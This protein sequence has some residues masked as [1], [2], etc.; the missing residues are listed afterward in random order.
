MCAPL[1]LVA[2]QASFPQDV[3][4]PATSPVEAL[5]L[6]LAAR[7]KLQD[8]VKR[9]HYVEA[10]QILIDALRQN[11]K[12]P[13][14]LTF[15]GGIYFLYGDYAQSVVALK[16][17]ER[18]SPLGN[19]DRFTLAMAYVILK[20]SDMAQPELERL[21]R[22]DPEKALYF[23][24]LSRVHYDQ[25]HYAEG[26]ANARKALQLDPEFTRA[27]DDLG[28][29]YEALGKYQEAI[30][31]YNQALTLN[32]RAQPP[33]PWPPLDFG[34]LLVKLNRLDEAHVYLEEALRYDER[35]PQGHYELGLLLDKQGKQKDAIRELRIAASL[36]PSYAE[37]H[38]ALGRIYTQ[39]GNLP[40]AQREFA[41]F[42]KIKRAKQNPAD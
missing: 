4:S 24:W 29:C 21:T 12:S 36:T 10:E 41:Q 11:P 6:G 8:A 17:A 27:Q 15:L 37:P 26:V 19:G 13:R 20:H 22:A 34:A 25:K 16:K 35:F 40:E 2:R 31:A 18:L 39:I 3:P 33:S 1:P 5:P 42:D 30:A 14:L 32:R 38:Y 7:A 23:Y 9:H 28:L